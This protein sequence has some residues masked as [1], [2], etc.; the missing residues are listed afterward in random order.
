LFKKIGEDSRVL[1]LSKLTKLR[2]FEIKEN[3]LAWLSV[4][5]KKRKSSP[6][7]LKKFVGDS[8]SR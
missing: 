5:L 4:K 1:K 6:P 2:V 3:E 7:I 8:I